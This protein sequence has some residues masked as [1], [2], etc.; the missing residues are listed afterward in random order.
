MSNRFLTAAR[1]LALALTLSACSS[2][3]PNNYYLLSAHTFPAP[4]G[5]APSLGIGPIRVPEYLSRQNI[6]YNH[7]DNALQV[8][9]LDL[10]GE[11]LENG[12]Q[13]VLAL[14]LTGMLNTQNVSYFPWQPGRAPDFGVEV[15]LLQLDANE[16]EALLVA[17]WLVYRP[18]KAESARR[19]ISRLQLPLPAGASQPEQVA[20]AYSTL[21]FQLS[22]TIA[23]AIESERAADSNIAAR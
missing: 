4:S 21:L 5:T 6:V 14:N 13:R 9:S 10:W 11:P 23:T 17:E 18:T 19:R 8:A 2:S 3:P 16:H 20:A 7:A 22:E 15:N 1:L 12:I